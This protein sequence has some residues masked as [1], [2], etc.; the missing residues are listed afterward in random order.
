MAVNVTG[1]HIYSV[2]FI[3]SFGVSSPSHAGGTRQCFS[4][5]IMSWKKRIKVFGDWKPWKSVRARHLPSGSDSWRWIL[6]GKSSCESTRGVPMN[7]KGWQVLPDGCSGC[8]LQPLYDARPYGWYAVI[9]NL[10]SSWKIDSRAPA[11][12]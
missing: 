3:E 6:T 10:S 4:T 11:V 12:C 5:G 9:W 2:M 7:C 1:T 8:R